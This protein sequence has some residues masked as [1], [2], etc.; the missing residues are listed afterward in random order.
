MSSPHQVFTYHRFTDQGLVEVTAPVIA[1]LPLLLVVNGQPWL[2]FLCTPTH[3][4]AL[5]AGF[6]FNENLISSMEDIVSIH[7]CASGDQV[8]VWTKKPLTRPTVW[9][10]T[11]GCGGGA[12]ADLSPSPTLPLQ[13]FGVLTSYAH[14]TDI[15][16]INARA[17]S[18]L[19]HELLTSQELYRLA[20]GIHAAALSD[21]STLFLQ[22]EDIG[23]HNTLDK[24]AGRLLIEQPTLPHPLLMTTGRVSSEMLQKSLRLGVQ[25]VVSRTSPTNFSIQMAQQ[26]NLTLIGY[27]RNGQYNIYTHNE[28]ILIEPVDES[29]QK[30]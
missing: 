3:L 20:H 13:D 24:L 17:L 30:S 14:D 22:V 27:A 9:R 2:E 23:R 11:S 28:R 16:K 6:L 29:S 18:R 10:R 26:A 1:E 5:T 19:M 21:G 4:E 25:I 7:L 15:F 8:D 12:T